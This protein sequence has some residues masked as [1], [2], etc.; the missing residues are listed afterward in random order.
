MIDNQRQK[1]SDNQLLII[2]F[3]FRL[4]FLLYAH[5]HD[6]FFEVKN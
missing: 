3:L 4:F 6:Y 1:W 5:L 2:A